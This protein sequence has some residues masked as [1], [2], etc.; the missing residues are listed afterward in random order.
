MKRKS[1]LVLSLMILLTVPLGAQ[2][3]ENR[4][5]EVIGT[6]EM[7][8]VPDEIHY[9][10]EIKEYFEEEFDGV[11]KPLNYKTKVRLPQIEEQLRKML[12]NIGIAEKAVR[13]QEVGEYWRKQRNEFLVA[14]ELDITLKDFRKIDE[15]VKNIDTKGVNSMRIGTLKNKNITTYRQQA[16]V[17]ALQ[18]AHEKA[19]LLVEALGKKLGSVIRIVEPQ[20]GINQYSSSHVS[21]AYSSHA[22]SFDAF[23][24][25]KLNYSMIVRFEIE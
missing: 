25:I 6:S 4:Y 21:N 24:T 14:K 16:K 1:L 15:I 8:I 9:I 3:E 19:A 10:I 7:E 23:R 5:I 20:E 22:Q 18:A 17:M 12:S 13:A 11:S 2:T